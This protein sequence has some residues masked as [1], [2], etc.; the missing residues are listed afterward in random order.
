MC[1]RDRFGPLAP[2]DANICLPAGGAFQVMISNLPPMFLNT[3]GPGVGCP[4]DA[5]DSP[6]NNG[7]SMCVD[8][9]DGVAGP[10]EGGPGDDNSVDFGIILPPCE[11]ISGIVFLDV[12][13]DG[14]DI[15]ETGAP[16]ITVE[17][18]DCS[19]PGAVPV[20]TAITA[21][22]GSYTFGPNAPGDANICLPAGGAFQVVISNLPPMT[23]FTTGAGVGCPG[24]ADDSPANNGMS[25]CVDPS[26]AT[27]GPG[28]SAPNDD[29]SV[30]FGIFA[31]IYDLALVKTVVTPGPYVPGQD[32]T[33]T[34]TIINQGNLDASN[35]TVTD[36][37]PVGMT[38]SPA[39]VG[40]TG[41]VGGPVSTI[42]PG[43]IAAGTSTSVDIILTIDP[44]VQAGSLV[45]NA[46]ITADDGD[47][48]DS[49]PGDNSQPNDFMDD[50]DAGETD[51]GDDEDPEAI[52]VGILACPALVCNDNLQIS[53][54][55]ECFVALLS[56]I[57]I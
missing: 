54:G 36:F 35:I 37:I 46:E 21:P 31:P 29:N 18:F 51:G 24:D 38:L 27:P 14:C 15:G 26:D 28:E 12:N 33:Y 20:A 49:T 5:D 55:L 17:L 43:P 8:P 45:N 48:V 44:S 9:D 56:L 39:A 2:G 7:V 23:A 40:W 19:M 57:H 50:N 47:D 22:D 6:G 25:L 10:G 30:D 52:E 34:I 13:E 1:I 4:G 3:P 41:P 53:V 11:D 16:G 42:I 32:V